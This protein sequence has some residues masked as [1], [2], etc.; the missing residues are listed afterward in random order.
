MRTAL[1]FSGTSIENP[2]ALSCVLGFLKKFLLLISANRPTDGESVKPSHESA[3]LARERTTSEFGYPILNTLLNG[4]L[5]NFP[6]DRDV[7]REVGKILYVAIDC[8]PDGSGL[9]SR[10]VMEL[11][12]S[13]EDEKRKLCEGIAQA[14]LL[15]DGGDNLKRLLNSFSTSYRRKLLIS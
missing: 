7:V 9:L 6:R 5:S 1:I 13:S 2:E 11:P 4:L 3:Q 12:L 14:S 8:I 15:Q 10:C